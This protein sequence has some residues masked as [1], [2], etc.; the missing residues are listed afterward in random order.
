MDISELSRIF[1]PINIY[2]MSFQIKEVKSLSGAKAHIYSVIFDGNDTTLLEQFF[3]ENLTNKYLKVMFN[4]IIVM[5]R[6]TGCLKQ[7]FKEGEGK[8]AD[9]VVALSVGNLRLYGIYFNNTV[10][11]LG[12][13][14]E[15]NVRAY[16]DD[17][18]LN[19]KVEQ[20]KY[21]AEKIYK[22]IREK[23]II[24]REDGELNYENF[25][26]YE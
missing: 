10:I 1:A 5:A 19:A 9:G 26:V 2:T 23:E 21:V 14:G 6:D 18:K 22:G 3:N 8:I 4:K 20:I 17:P 7:F 11:L 15:K 12:S 24:V 16:Q 25:D 13:G